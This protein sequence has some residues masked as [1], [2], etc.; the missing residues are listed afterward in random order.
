MRFF[1]IDFTIIGVTKIVRY[2]RYIEDF[3]IKRFVILRFQGQRNQGK[4]QSKTYN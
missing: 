1:F 4:S 2:V 3:V